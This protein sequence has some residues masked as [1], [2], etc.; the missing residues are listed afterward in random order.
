MNDFTKELAQGQWH[1]SFATGILS[2]CS[3][4]SLLEKMKN[5]GNKLGS[6]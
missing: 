1:S 2:F 6:K 3:C 5:S 4:L